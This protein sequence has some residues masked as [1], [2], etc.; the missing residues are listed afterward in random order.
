LSRLKEPLKQFIPQVNV[1]KIDRLVGTGGT[2]TSTVDDSQ[3]D[4]MNLTRDL[5]ASGGKD[6]GPEQQLFND[7]GVLS[8]SLERGAPKIELKR[9]LGN[10]ILGANN[11][12]QEGQAFLGTE[13]M[14]EALQKQM[15]EDYAY[16]TPFKR[17]WS[18]KKGPLEIGQSFNAFNL[19]RPSLGKSLMGRTDQPPAIRE[20]KLTKK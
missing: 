19:V 10:L 11:P 4:M 18:R 5:L 7:T 17:I 16:N 2:N 6:H 14:K 15:T 8:Q 9:T 3:Y 13:G 20:P 12:F 1:Q